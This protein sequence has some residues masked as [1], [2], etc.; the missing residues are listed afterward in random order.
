M[1]KEWK[2]NIKEDSLLP[3]G[4]VGSTTSLP[5]YIAYS[6]KFKVVLTY[7]DFNYVIKLFSEV[8]EILS[9]CLFFS[10]QFTKSFVKHPNANKESKLKLLEAR[11]MIKRCYLPSEA[12]PLDIS[13]LKLPKY[14]RERLGRARHFTVQ[15]S[16]EYCIKRI[17][18]F[19]LS[20]TVG[21][22]SR[23]G[24]LDKVEV[25]FYNV[26]CIKWC[27]YTQYMFFFNNVIDIFARR[28]FEKDDYH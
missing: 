6:D 1:K 14:F 27:D 18:K 2:A 16:L 28:M 3:V 20:T 8:K 23:W 25:S 17:S 24:L 13:E 12:P 26:L 7:K 21:I 22:W 9:V 10:C 19:L 11:H 5:Y 4:S 15:G